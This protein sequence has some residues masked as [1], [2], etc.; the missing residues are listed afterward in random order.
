MPRSSCRS[1]PILA[2]LPCLLAGCGM[3]SAPSHVF[4]GAYFPSWLLFALLWAL[5]AVGVR[6]AMVLAGG[7]D[8]PWPLALCA[9]AGFLLALGAWLLAAGSPP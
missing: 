6:V 5:L 1:R 7:G 2:L 3:A 9:A 8:W 4:F